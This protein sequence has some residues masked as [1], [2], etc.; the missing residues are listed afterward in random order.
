[1]VWQSE[2]GEFSFLSIKYNIKRIGEGWL[3]FENHLLKR[4]KSSPFC[5][6][7]FFYEADTP[8]KDLTCCK[9]NH[10]YKEIFTLY[11]KEENEI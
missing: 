10:I 9:A 4:I 11:I 1:M 3:L 7:C 6:G 5:T 2:N 8:C